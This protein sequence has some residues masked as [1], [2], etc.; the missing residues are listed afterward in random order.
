MVLG[1]ADL[2]GTVQLVNMPYGLILQD[3]PP[4]SPS[5]LKLSSTSLWLRHWASYQFSLLAP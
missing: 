1:H 5:P 4:K 2:I 3:L